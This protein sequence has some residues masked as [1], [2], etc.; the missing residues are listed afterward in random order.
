M[1]LK[2][3]FVEEKLMNESMGTVI[4]IVYDDAQGN[5]LIGALPLYIVVD[6]PESTLSYNLILGSPSTHIPIPITTERCERKCCYM[7]TIPLIVC[8]TITTYKSQGITVG[9]GKTW[10][11]VVV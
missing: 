10:K 2:N 6:F 9:P 7:T 8:K 4:D 1:L 3:F 11:R 5:K